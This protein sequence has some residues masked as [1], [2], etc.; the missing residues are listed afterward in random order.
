MQPSSTRERVAVA[1]A[2]FSAG[3]GGVTIAATRL[4]V[5]S[6]DPITINAVRFGV[7]F[8]LLLA[9]AVTLR[10]PWPRREDWFSVSLLGVLAFVVFSL[11]FV[12]AMQFTISA[13]AGLAFS[14]MPLQTMI[15]AAAFGVQRLTLRRSL[16]VLIAIGGVAVA[17]V[18]GLEGAPPGAWRGDL[19][20]VAAV[21]VM[22]AYVVLS[23][24]LI[25]RCHPLAFLT[26]GMGAGEAILL[27]LAV[28]SGGFSSLA[29]YG[30]AQWLA[31]AFLAVGGGAAMFILWVF[32]LGRT[33]PT[34]AAVSVGVN[35][36]MAAIT[37]ALMLGEPIGP[38]LLIGLAGVFAGL[39]LATSEGRRTQKVA[40]PGSPR[41][42][43]D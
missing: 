31:M 34:Q 5:A 39:W 43:H 25:V 8:L 10:V 38:N 35:P 19:I 12:A 4:L 13:R 1:A 41:R 14:T 20:M 32:A 33:G 40:P 6:S 36:I 2:A 42:A 37:G 9:A 26:V 17:L 24:P 30:P 7:A 21:L 11:L 16:G 3:L 28:A 27:G 22:S 23:R 29:D 15:I 18:A